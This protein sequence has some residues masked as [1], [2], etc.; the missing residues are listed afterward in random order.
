MNKYG[1]IKTMRIVFWSMVFLFLMPTM[2]YS[3][4]NSQYRLGPGDQ[5]RI[6][7]FNHPDLSGEFEVDGSGRLSLPLIQYVD[8]NGLA[9]TELEAA[10][11]AKL[12]P[13]YL[14]DPKISVEILSKRPFY[15]LG[16][17]KSPGSYPYVDGLTVLT[18]IAI[19]GGY[20]YRAHKRKV[21]I[22][23]AKDSSGSEIPTTELTPIYPGD[24]IKVPERRF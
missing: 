10:I 21:K 1:V 8:A 13:N 19:A 3:Q 4:S 5:V 18:A 15:I 20:T 7:V 22:V 2:G 17:V 6:T 12:S 16:E 24:V 11:R 9:A 23:R 14:K